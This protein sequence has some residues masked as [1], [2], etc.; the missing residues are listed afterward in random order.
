MEEEVINDA[1]QRQIYDPIKKVFDYSKRRV[2]DLIE[3]NRVALPKEAEP[4]IE[5]E[6]GMLREII[7][8]EFKDY[9]LEL[10]R[11]EIKKGIKEEK[12]INQKEK[13]LSI[14]EKRGLKKIR[15]RIKEKEVVVLKTDKSGKMTIA[16]RESYLEMGRK[17]NGADRKIEREELKIRE[18]KINE[19]TKMWSKIINA[20]EA[21]GHNDRIRSSKN[22]ESEIAASKYYMFKDHKEGESYRPVVSGCCSNTLGLSGLLSDII[23]S[24]CL[25]MN[26]PFEV[27]SSEDMLAEISEFNDKVKREIEKDENYDWRDEYVLLGTDVISLF[28][29]MS[30]ERTGEAIRKQVERSSIKWEEIDEKWLTLYIRLNRDL[31]YKYE[32]IE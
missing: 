1:K 32:E 20:G 31:S 29:S 22:I 11:E 18:R 3:N 28:P 17:L 13:N 23:E 16:D 4:R 9:K 19:H 10:E 2:T 25:A 24:L 7:L 26:D 8:K 14:Q 5:N 12:R 27:I 15:Q 6:L 21:H 30:A